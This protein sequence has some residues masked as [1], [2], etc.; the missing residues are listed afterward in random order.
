M[1][2]K[3]YEIIQDETKIPLLA[4]E[5]ADVFQTQ[6][7]DENVDYSFTINRKTGKIY[8]E[9]SCSNTFFEFDPAPDSELHQ[10]KKA[11]FHKDLEEIQK[12]S[13]EEGQLMNDVREFLVRVCKYVTDNHQEQLKETVRRVILGGRVDEAVAPLSTI[14]VLMVDIADYDSVPDSNKYL[15]KISKEVDEDGNMAE[16]N[17]DDIVL[18][19]QEQ[20]E[21]TGESIQSI[22]ETEKLAGN[23]IFDGV[24]RVEK[25]RKFLTEMRL[26]IFVDYSLS[27]EAIN[28]ET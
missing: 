18:F 17:T 12:G 24:L 14:E 22:F 27:D 20:E 15:L 6:A 8:D 21:E 13:D 23:P 25:G 10:L 1:Q 26:Y 16:V 2:K 19:L 7:D 28:A 3:I 4:K 9:K 5:M 11:L